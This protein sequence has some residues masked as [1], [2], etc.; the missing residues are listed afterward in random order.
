MLS[1]SSRVKFPILQ[2]VTEYDP[3][4]FDAFEEAGWT[5]KEA[6]AY[7][8]LLGRVTPQVAEPLLDAVGARRGT[9]LL[10][11]AT[12][13]GYVAAKRPSAVRSRLASTSPRRCSLM[14]AHT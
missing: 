14:H 3:D 5:T 13:P 2:V 9:R 6:S 8:R 1:H 11:V 10:D 7:H 12:G 4:A